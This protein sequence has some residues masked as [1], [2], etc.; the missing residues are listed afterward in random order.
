MDLRS[1]VTPCV[2]TMILASWSTGALPASS[3]GNVDRSCITNQSL[4]VRG[5]SMAEL[6]PAGMEIVAANGYYKCNK[7]QRGDVAVIRRPGRP[8][9]LLIKIL[10]LL[11]GDRFAFKPLDA[12]TSGLFVNDETEPLKTP[13]GQPYALKGAALTM[14]Q[15]YWE[16]MKGVVPADVY[17]VLGTE[18]SGSFDSTRFGPI[19]AQDLV[20]RVEKPR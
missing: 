1:S 18:P 7:A 2:L 19:T 14:L 20:G 17:F 9:E 10:V 16:S 11:P 8:A 12:S 3:G 5:Q 15:Q 6:Y 13:K 4:T